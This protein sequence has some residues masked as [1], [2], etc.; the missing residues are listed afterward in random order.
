MVQPLQ[1][2]ANTVIKPVINIAE[3]TYRG[4]SDQFSRISNIVDN[5]P[6][7]LRGVVYAVKKVFESTILIAI[8]FLAPP[9]VQLA[10]WAIHAITVIVDLSTNQNLLDLETT[11]IMCRG[12][13]IAT[14]LET[15]VN[16]GLYAIAPK[17][18]H[19]I[20]SIVGIAAS[21]LYFK[22]AQHY[23]EKFQREYPVTG[24]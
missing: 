19:I 13:G 6:P 11:S 10:I 3:M 5:A 8:Y 14:A 22:G 16:L 17:P 2:V 23:E 24:G 9:P 7:C 12:F 18:L 4:I 21:F 20:A 15:C 1:F